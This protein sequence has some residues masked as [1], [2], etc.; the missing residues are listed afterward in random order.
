MEK[1]IIIAL[2]AIAVICA[3]VTA[4]LFF[5]NDDNPDNEVVSQK[6][7]VT[8]G[9]LSRADFVSMCVYLYEQLSG[10]EAPS[11]ETGGA[12]SSLAVKKAYALGIIDIDDSVVFSGGST[13]SREE[14]ATLLYRSASAY[15]PTIRT[16]EIQTGKI[17]NDCYDNMSID[18]KAAC[19]FVINSGAVKKQS[20]FCPKNTITADEATDWINTVYKLYKSDH[21]VVFGDNR[22]IRCGC[23]IGELI[24]IMGQPTRIDNSFYDGES[25]IYNIDGIYAIFYVNHGAVRGFFSN[26]G[27]KSTTDGLEG[28]ENTKKLCAYYTAEPER[29][30]KSTEAL[31]E[32]EQTEFFEMLNAY[33]AEN[34]IGELIEHESLMALAL[35][36]SKS[37]SESGMDLGIPEKVAMVQ[38][39]SI[40]QMYIT[41]MTS[42]KYKGAIL[43]ANHDAYA[44]IGLWYGSIEPCI[45]IL[46]DEETRVQNIS[47]RQASQTV[48]STPEPDYSGNA[49]V[50]IS[51]TAE[52]SVGAGAPIVIRLAEKTADSFIARVINSETG[53]M[54]VYARVYGDSLTVLPD[55]LTDGYDYMVTASI[56]TDE[57][58]LFSEISAVRYGIPE[59]PQIVSPL[60]RA[61]VDTAAMSISWKSR[62]SDFTVSIINESGEYIASQ[63]VVGMTE[64]AVEGL[65]DGKYTIEVTAHRKNT[66]EILSS[67]QSVFFV[68]LSNVDITTTERPSFGKN[69]YSSLFGGA[70]VYS[71]K[72]Q[73]DA[74]MRTI[75]VSVWSIGA[76][77]AKYPNRMS[78]TVNKAI[79]DE[80]QQIFAEIFAGAEKFPIKSL[81]GYNWRSTA[82]G[83]RSQHSYGTCIDINPDENYCIYNSGT[84]I[85]KLWK[86]HEN[87]YSITPDGD[88]V[89]V[90]KSHGWTWG[91]EWNSVKDYMHFSYLGG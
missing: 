47:K 33:R 85:G 45:T 63:R 36:N 77:G 72:A 76:D 41:L 39:G 25:Y 5:G 10:E 67:A 9:D 57:G 65:S 64:A 7:T 73:A 61:F 56:Q 31:R 60:A 74:N 75:T 48:K 66:N 87:P 21:E 91:G 78:L 32:V 13:L 34:G 89:R 43:R 38:G 2:A 90:F 58:E 70:M 86:P 20:R 50:L 51:P 19:A 49:P 54:A 3:I 88:V 42:P 26:R 16:D 15:K 24:E 35:E 14:A 8:D 4:A 30:K 22:T 68:Q 17:L 27:V 44:G 69:R 71:S 62:Y 81:G 83:T 52:D 40:E 28:L 18:D 55:V 1:K 53:E 12:N 23:T 59:Q 46:I 79:A 37:V 84:R 29:V 11:R 82:T 80:V 6:M